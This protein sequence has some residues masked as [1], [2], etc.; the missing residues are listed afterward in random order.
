MGLGKAGV[1]KTE[2][3][4]TGDRVGIR[5]LCGKGSCGRVLPLAGSGTWDDFWEMALDTDRKECCYV[6][7][8]EKT[9]EAVELSKKVVIPSGVSRSVRIMFVNGLSADISLELEMSSGTQLGLYIG[10]M[11]NTGDKLNVHVRSEQEEADSLFLM[12]GRIVAGSGSSCT[13]A[14]LGRIGV[15]A[16]RCS[17]EYDV[18]VLQVGKGG[19]VRG[20]PHMEIL[21]NDVKADHGFSVGRVPDEMKMYMGS[22]GLTE[23]DAERMYAEGFTFM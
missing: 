8:L 19:Q 2:L 9:E 4:E 10:G 20:E 17:C 7:K 3:S 21:R 5:H 22:R 6:L 11:L 23:E 1:G 15:R 12:K 18:R 16:K 14:T 13:A